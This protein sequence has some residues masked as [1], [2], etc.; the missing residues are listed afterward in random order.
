VR[1]GSVWSSGG[2]AALPLHTVHPGGVTFSTMLDSSVHIHGEHR[3]VEFLAW[4]RCSFRADTIGFKLIS[5]V[6]AHGEH[7]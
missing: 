4:R 2:Y 6:P 3:K 1:R 7:R 5:S